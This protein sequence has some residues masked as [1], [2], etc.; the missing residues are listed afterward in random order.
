M[1]HMALGGGGLRTVHPVVGV[2]E[3]G[4]CSVG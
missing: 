4:P 1:A 2:A 3:G